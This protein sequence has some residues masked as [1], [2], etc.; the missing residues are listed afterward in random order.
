MIYYYDIRNLELLL[1]GCSWL[2]KMDNLQ[3]ILSLDSSLQLKYFH[4]AG[5]TYV[6]TTDDQL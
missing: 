4:V 5:F 2:L 3:F 1:F 6:D